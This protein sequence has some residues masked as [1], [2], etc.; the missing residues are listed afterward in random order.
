MTLPLALLHGF[1]GS[2]ASFDAVRGAFEGTSRVVAPALVGHGDAVDAPATTFED[3][4]DRI[5]GVLRAVT[6]RW[7]IAGYSLGGRVAIGLLLRHPELFAGAVL[8]GA[9]PGLATEEERAARRRDDA[10]LCTLLEDE[11]IES[12]V[13]HW[14]ALP[15]FRTQTALGGRVLARQRVE[16]LAHDPRG[17]ARSLRATGLGVM[18]SYEKALSSVEAPTTW[19]AGSRDDK[20]V[21]IA[22]RMATA[23]P[24]ATV[25][26]VEGAGHNV[27]LERPE[28]FVGIV[29]RAFERTPGGRP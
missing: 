7:Q 16:R 12:F 14:E 21:A 26:L 24:R 19:V 10:R 13:R 23:M 29:A 18:P 17:L 5:A 22:R 9:Q 6:P 20:F 4:V 1:T 3:E 11:G 27:I 8:V 28:A 25:A 2:P 15:L